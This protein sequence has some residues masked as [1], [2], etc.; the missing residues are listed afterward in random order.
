MANALEAWTSVRSP[1]PASRTAPG[2]SLG[3]VPA[4]MP[5]ER[6]RR[7]HADFDKQT[8]HDIAEQS[9]VVPA[10]PAKRVRHTDFVHKPT[11]FATRTTY[12]ETPSSPPP[13]EDPALVLIDDVSALALLQGDGTLHQFTED[14]EE[15]AEARRRQRTASVS[16]AWVYKEFAQYIRCR[17]GLWTSGPRRLMTG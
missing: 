6:K 12:F 14:D 10:P 11:G 8:H 13:E 5:R 7:R 15:E 4:S 17:T 1:H 16:A 2:T 9:S 3:G